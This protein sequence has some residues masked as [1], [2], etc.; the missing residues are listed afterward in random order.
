MAHIKSSQK[1]GT[2]YLFSK[3]LNEVILFIQSYLSR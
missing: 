3:R 1:H 2:R